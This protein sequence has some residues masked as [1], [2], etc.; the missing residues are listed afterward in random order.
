LKNTLANASLNKSFLQNLFE[1]I[2]KNPLIQEFDK[3]GFLKEKP[4]LR[5]KKL[6]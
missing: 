1:K 2:C 5:W 4:T 3:N 6:S